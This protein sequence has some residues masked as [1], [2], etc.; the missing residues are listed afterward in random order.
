METRETKLGERAFAVEWEGGQGKTLCLRANLGPTAVG[1]APVGAVGEV[2]EAGEPEVLF[3][4]PARFQ[5]QRSQSL[6]WTQL[7]PWSVIWYLTPKKK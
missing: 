6:K 2:S 3:V 4:T 5:T 7:E 1:C